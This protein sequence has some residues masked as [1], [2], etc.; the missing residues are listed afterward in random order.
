MCNTW[1]HPSKKEEEFSPDLVDKLPSNLSFINITGGEPFLR[2]DLDDLV[3]SAYQHCR[4]G[5]IT[6]PTNGM[7]GD[8]VVD[9][10][11]RICR[12]CPES[13]IGINLSLDGIG[14][15]HNPPPVPTIHQR[16]DKGSQD[17]LGKECDHGRSGKYDA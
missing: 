17:D 12:E 3:I 15:E 6:I 9:M 7:L 5:V 11:T 14:D 2:K 10:T 13:S 16:S 1:Q 8:R 4:P